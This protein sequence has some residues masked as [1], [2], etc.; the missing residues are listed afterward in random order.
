M[1]HYFYSR[2][3]TEKKN[4]RLLFLC[5][6][7][8]YYIC[9]RFFFIRFSFRAPFGRFFDQFLVVISEENFRFFLLPIDRKW[10]ETAGTEFEFDTTV[11]HNSEFGTIRIQCLLVSLFTR[12]RVYQPKHNIH[13][14]HLRK[15]LRNVHSGIRSLIHRLR[16]SDLK[17]VNS[18]LL[19]IIAFNRNLMQRILIRILFFFFHPFIFFLHATKTINKS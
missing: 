5:T 7:G 11:V 12:S 6:T 15:R 10:S 8:A 2:R 4:R 18:S 13:H 1:R 14:Y 19:P 3:S 16:V 9:S 17:C